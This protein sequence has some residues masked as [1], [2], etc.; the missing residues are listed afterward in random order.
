M[1][2]MEPIITT[3]ASTLVSAAI[4]LHDGSYQATE[5]YQFSPAMS[6]LEACRRAEDKAKNAIIMKAIGSNLSGEKAATCL[7]QNN[8][9]T[10]HYYDETFEDTRGYIKE[11]KDKKHTVE[12]WTCTATV[13]ATVGATGKVNPNFDMAV[14]LRRIYQHGEN[15]S[16]DV[17]SNANAD[18][19]IF[20]YDPMRGTLEKIFPARFENDRFI[21]RNE[22]RTI[23]NPKN[24]RF[25]I[26][27]VATRENDD[28]YFLFVATK[29]RVDFLDTYEVNA[30]Y[31]MWNRIGSEKRLVKKGIVI[32]R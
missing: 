8:N 6:Q 29:E 2:S 7:E 27:A 32:V 24:F 5:Q 15:I 21:Y 17:Q 11:V 13:T 19:Y 10:C 31:N 3:I 14:N 23:P 9:R 12:G 22:T 28:R 25:K 4:R 18:L 20:S 26:P 1:L 16:F 30:F